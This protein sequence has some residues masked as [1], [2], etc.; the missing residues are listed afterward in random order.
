MTKEQWRT[1]VNCLHSHIGA[2]IEAQRE[3][4]QQHVDNRDTGQLWAL[5][6]SLLAYGF[7]SF[8]DLKQFR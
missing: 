8:F 5:I 4:L 7:R 1:E 3:L 2:H 6:S